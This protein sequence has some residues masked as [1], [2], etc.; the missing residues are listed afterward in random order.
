MLLS[1]LG[2]VARLPGTHNEPKD[3]QLKKL[4][5]TENKQLR[6]IWG[7]CI[8]FILCHTC[9]IVR[10]IEQ[11]YLKLLGIDITKPE[12]CN[13]ACAST[14]TLKSHVSFVLSKVPLYLLN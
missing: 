5:K 2:S 11:L 3:M 14:M 1:S 10:N 12:P 4:Q 8:L 6:I 7:V 9:R 13:Y